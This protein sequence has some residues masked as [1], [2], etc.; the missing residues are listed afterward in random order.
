MNLPTGMCW[1]FSRRLEA[2]E[3]P[4]LQEFLARQAQ[5]DLVPWPVQLEAASRY[6]SSIRE[7]EMEIL[8]CGLLPARYQRNRQTISTEEQRL[9]FASRVTVIGCGGLGG[10]ILEELARLGVGQLV[11]VDYDVFEEH[12][13]N[14]QL[15]A[16][17]VTLGTHKVDAA[18]ERITA[19]NPA[20]ELIP[21]REAF[22]KENGSG[23]LA[24][25]RVAVDAL[26]S[27]PVRRM[28]SSCCRELDI[29][30]V[31]GAICGWFGQ[32][33]TQYPGENT[34]ETLYHSCT[35]AKGMEKQ[36]GNP[37]F[38]PAVIASLQTAEVCKV[39]LGRGTPLNKR[40]LYVN[41]LDMELEEVQL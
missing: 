37:S 29:P 11:A 32:V 41:L 25:S 6:H 33:A 23:I 28:L 40:V 8:N 20:V 39:L 12:N 22:T 38:T 13:L 4:S 16:L 7:I 2:V 26:D 31:H 15:L 34:L 14:R 9:L 1:P 5:G 30:L 17:P 19:I 36:Y 35:E 21:V 3:M 27:I 10:Y 18:A 24:G